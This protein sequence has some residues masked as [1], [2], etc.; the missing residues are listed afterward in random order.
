[1][2]ATIHNGNDQYGGNDHIVQWKLHRTHHAIF[3][4]YLMNGKGRTLGEVIHC[5]PRVAKSNAITRE[6]VD[7][8]SYELYRPPEDPWA[9]LGLAQACDARLRRLKKLGTP[10]D[11]KVGDFSEIF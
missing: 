4:S 3:V 9:C 7:L 10:P 5:D 1:M 11:R 8:R 2:E 6:V